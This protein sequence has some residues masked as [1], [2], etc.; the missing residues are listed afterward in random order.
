MT[1]SEHDPDDVT[2]VYLWHDVPPSPLQR[3]RTMTMC[4]LISGI[5]VSAWFLT[6]L[7]TA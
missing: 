1:G 5:A 7:L 2:W 3:R 6:Q 4:A